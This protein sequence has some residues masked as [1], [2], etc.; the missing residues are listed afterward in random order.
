MEVLAITLALA[1]AAF[2]LVTQALRR[3]EAREREARAVELANAAPPTLIAPE[4]EEWGPEAWEELEELEELEGLEP[5]E[6][7]PEQDADDEQTADD[8]RAAADLL[9]EADNEQGAADPLD[10]TR[11]API[12]DT[13]AGHKAIGRAVV[14]VLLGGGALYVIV[15]GSSSNAE[16]WA[17][18][19]LGALLA[20]WV[21]D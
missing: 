19:A 16:N 12:H 10:E 5:E 20:Y 7:G 21:R 8:E 18:G 15:A 14:S 3:R 13:S 6:W 4:P 9:D 11:L 1:T 17:S 2:I